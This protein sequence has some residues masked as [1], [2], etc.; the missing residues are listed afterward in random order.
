V[1]LSM[2]VGLRQMLVGYWLTM[3]FAFLVTGIVIQHATCGVHNSMWDYGTP[4]PKYFSIAIG[5]TATPA[6]FALMVSHGVTRRMFSVAAGIYLTGAAAA[7]SMLWVLVHRVEHALY[8]WQGRP[9]NLT[10]PHRFTSTSQV[11]LVFTE[12]FLLILSHEVAGWLLGITFFRF[13]FW[14]GVLLLPLAL[15][16]AAAAESL[17][18]A[19]WL[20]AVLN[21]AG[22]HRPPLAVA[23]PAVLVVSALGL[24]AGYR[25]L[26]PVAVKP[27]KG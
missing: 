26:R 23:V 8:S 17:L 5:I 21:N 4:S 18:V 22:Y 27:G 15:L 6:Y 1:L 13:G 12:F 16:P 25:V 20:A 7:T 11:G 2:I 9:G 3:V 10:N 14:R 24:Y 19:E